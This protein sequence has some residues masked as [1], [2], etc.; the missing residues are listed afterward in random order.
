MTIEEIDRK[1]EHLN[2]EKQIILEEKIK[3]IKNKYVNKYFSCEYQGFKLYFK[4][5]DF[6]VL[7]NNVYQLISEGYRRINYLDKD[8]TITKCKHMKL[9][10]NNIRCLKLLTYD[11]YKIIVNTFIEQIKIK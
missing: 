8:I 6:L 3:D 2:K 9:N 11:C 5:I 4:V 1:I 10:F 7:K